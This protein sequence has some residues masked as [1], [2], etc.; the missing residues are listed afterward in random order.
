MSTCTD[1]ATRLKA[2]A[3]LPIIIAETIHLTR[4]GKAWTAPCQFHTERTPS[5]HVFKDH[6]H[7]FGCGAHG[8][9]YDWLEKQRG[10]S[11]PDAIR[12]LGG[13]Q[14]TAPTPPPRP[15]ARTAGPPPD[16]EALRKLALA[17]RTWDEAVAPRGTL[18]EAYLAVRGVRLPDADVLRFHP[19]CPRAGGVLPAMVALMTEPITDEFRGVHRTFLKSDGR[20]KADVHKPRMMLGATG[21]VQ[22]ADLHEIGVGLGLAEGIETALSVTQT[23]GWGPVWAA[24]SAGAIR[25]FPFM[26]QTTLNIFSDGDTAG[27]NAARACSGR[28]VKASANDRTQR[29]V[30]DANGRAIGDFDETNRGVKASAEVLIHAPPA[31]KDWNDVAREMAA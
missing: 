1:E 5:F 3:S 24:G 6:Y 21:I 17:R 26:P 15:A 19:R 13:N 22:L 28:W 12:Y 29:R 20:G 23:I 25:A 10:L 18:V 2:T 9:V 11:F 16:G 30:I 31:G 8:D 27:L 14:T 7:C 4:D